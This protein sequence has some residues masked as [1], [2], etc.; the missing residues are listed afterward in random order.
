MDINDIILSD[1]ALS[2]ID[3]GTWV[4]DFDAAPGLE[5]LVLG[6]RSTDAQKSMEAKQAQA[7]LKN[8]N[9]ALTEKQ[10]SRLMKETLAEVVLKGWKG[11]KDGKKPVEFSKEL[12]E[13]WMLSRNGEK[14]VDIVLQAAERVDSQTNDFVGQVSK[15]SSPT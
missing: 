12:A 1:E 6:L 3:N 10:L 5:L 7:R 14:F 15:N 4:G 8:R 2:V 9:R 11:L 13:K